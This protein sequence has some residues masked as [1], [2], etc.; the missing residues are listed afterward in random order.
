MNF[1]VRG[2]ENSDIIYAEN[3]ER[4]LWK[5][6]KSCFFRR[7]TEEVGNVIQLTVKA[8]ENRYER[9]LDVKG[10]SGV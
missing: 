4:G 8:S 3:K 2:N 10:N 9:I 6:L 5:S 7:V 1:I